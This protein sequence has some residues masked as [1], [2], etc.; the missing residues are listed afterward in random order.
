MYELVIL[1]GA[2]R[3]LERLDPP[4]RRRIAGRL[5]WVAEHFDEVQPE[6]LTG[7]YAGWFKIRVGDY[8]ILYQFD[9]AA[10]NLTIVKIRHRREVYE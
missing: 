1:P 7:D 3:D 6:A 5:D 8:R 2:R 9:R 4:V 10:H